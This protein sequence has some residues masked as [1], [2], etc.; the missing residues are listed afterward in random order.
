MITLQ[1]SYSNK[2][3]LKT[4]KKKS[5][6]FY[7]WTQC[8][9]SLSKS[10]QCRT[11]GSPRWSPVVHLPPRCVL[12]SQQGAFEVPVLMVSGHGSSHHHEVGPHPFI[13]A[14]LL[15]FNVQSGPHSTEELHFWSILE[16]GCPDLQAEE[17]VQVGSQACEDVPPGVELCYCSN[18]RRKVI[19]G[20]S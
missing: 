1:K 16:V 10:P 17:Y 8:C 3:W 2:I 9:T 15:W 18:N 6:V 12:G 5:S 7:N 4:N 11:K 13:S 19:S 14:R 20:I